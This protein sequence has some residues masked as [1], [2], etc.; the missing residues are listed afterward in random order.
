MKKTL[1]ILLLA[2]AALFAAADDALPS[3]GLDSVDF[4]KGARERA[5]AAKAGGKN[6]IG[7]ASCRERV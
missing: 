7:R 4:F 5:T 3:G 1:A 2:T 6:Q